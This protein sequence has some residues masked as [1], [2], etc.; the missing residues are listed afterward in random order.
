MTSSGQHAAGAA[1]NAVVVGGGLV[2]SLLA[3]FLVR[4]GWSVRV[5][6]KRPDLRRTE[7]SAGRSINLVITNRGFRALDRVGLEREARRLTVPVR[8]RMIHGLDGALAYQPY[9]R[10][11]SESNHSISRTEL[12]RFLIE[13]AARRGVD[14]RFEAR[15]ER[16][17]LAAGRLTFV[18]ERRGERLDVACGAVFG[19]DGAG[20]AVRAEMV[21]AAVC[22]ESVEPLEHGYK[23]LVIPAVEGGSHRIE[24]NA[25]HLWPRGNVMLMALANLDGSFT[26]TLYLP[27]RGP[28]SFESLGAGADVRA[29]FALRFPDA[30]PLIPDLEQGF[31]ANP[32]GSLGTVRCR[33]WHAG[34]RA[35]LLG[36][37][38]HAVVPFFGQGM[39]C[40]FEDCT[41]LDELLDREGDAR[42]DRVFA[43]LTA[44][45]RPDADAIADMALDNFVEMRDRVGDERFLLRKQVEHVL[46]QAMP[47]EYRSRYSMVMYSHVP[48]H[49]AQEAGRI[50]D[51][52]LEELCAG[53][54]TAA[55]LDLEQA[56]RLVR[57]RL[58]PFLQRHAVSL[59]Y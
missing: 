39:N 57:E 1:P 12:N 41:I 16:V 28:E 5:Y 43:E 32:T 29:L 10:N 20:S 22:R 19:T 59:D 3:I 26:V 40:G 7:R 44:A 24:P 31:F 45:R 4:R 36:D 35:L 47:R 21:R 9:G 13:Q 33:P 8:G 56:R 37:A 18:D 34:G 17:D 38:A 54:D 55:D 48:Y 49:L 50:H 52:I 25:L 2:G 51:G 11:E 27:Q 23:E 53:L 42:L 15:L 30:M 58:A 6:E 46:E 14:F